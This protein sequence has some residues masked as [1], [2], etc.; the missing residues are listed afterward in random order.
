M[1]VDGGNL[2]QLTHDDADDWFPVWSP[3]GTQIIFCSRRDGGDFDIYLMDT[4]GTLLR[5]LT[6][7]PAEDFNATWQPVRVH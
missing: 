7:N 1:D 5:R 2:R 6:D 4:G 3:D